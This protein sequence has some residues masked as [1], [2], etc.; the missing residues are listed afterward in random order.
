MIRMVAMCCN[1]LQRVAT[2]F[3]QLF[4]KPMVPTHRMPPW[5]PSTGCTSKVATLPRP[6]KQCCRSTRN[7][8]RWWGAIDGPGNWFINGY[9]SIPINTIFRGMNIH[10]SQLFWCEL[11]GYKVLTHCQMFMEGGY[12][13]FWTVAFV[14]WIEECFYDNHSGRY[15]YQWNMVKKNQWYQ[16]S[17]SSCRMAS[18]RVR[19]PTHTWPACRTMVS[20]LAKLAW[21]ISLYLQG[22]IGKLLV[23][24]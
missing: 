7:Q 18:A 14:V 1:V 6:P 3:T 21:H 12:V 19:S 4:P 24:V 5:M 15:P 16:G 23:D 13:W 9:G 17:L 11:Q 20:P 8:R 10:K 22:N 2:S